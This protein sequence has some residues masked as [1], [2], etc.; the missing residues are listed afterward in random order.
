MST[1]QPAPNR[2]E[3]RRGWPV[4][5]GAVVG[6]GAGPALFQNLSSMFV[7]GMTGE[8]GWSRGAV[9]AASG[10]GFAGSL[11]VPL[12]GRMVDR[13]GVRPMIVGCMVALAAA[14]L[15]MATMGGQLW[16]YHLL[17]LALA[18]TVP[19]TSALA[20][21][22]LIAARFFAHRGLALGIAT[23]GL[24]LTT[25]L[26]PIVLAEVIEAFG[27]RGGFVALALYSALIALPIALV[28]IRTA[29]P[30]TRVGFTELAHVSGVTAPQ[31]RRDPR[32]W[33]LGLTGFFVNLG[34]IGFVTQLVPFGIDHDLTGKQAALLLTA[35]GAS[36]VAARVTFGALI[37]RYPPQRIAATVAGVS[38][39]GFAALQWPGLTLPGLMAGVFCA[40]LMNGAEN[41]LFP[42]FA[43]RLFGLRAY[44]EVYGTL[45][46]V[47]LVGSGA[48]IIGFGALHDATG[49]DAAGLAV[50]STA[51]AIAGLL[52]TGL[53]DRPAQG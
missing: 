36:Q 44:G 39:L 23:S 30:V 2:S 43:A 34:T 22:K 21:G 9:A 32:F 16:H 15:G 33:R 29:G 24:P 26:L 14:Y 17:V 52:F 6:S 18:M 45:I 1:R 38:A 41:D 5:L 53:R 46:V 19:G 27:W 25:L 42:F 50:A 31:A 13:I 12:L 37:D 47:A 48:G 28:A 7:P 20:Y 10:L 3:W 35:F 4:V 40:G 49:G 8:F 11:A 51:L